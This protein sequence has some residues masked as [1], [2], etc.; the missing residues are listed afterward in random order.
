M[1]ATST[2]ALPISHMQQVQ[3]SQHQA[4]ALA[5]QQAQQ[6]HMLQ[7]QVGWSVVVCECWCVVLCFLCVREQ[8]SLLRLVLSFLVCC[9]AVAV[10]TCQNTIVIS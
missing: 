8:D 6:Q 9:T 2:A 3:M 7:Q 4:Q 1:F 5:Q 10:V